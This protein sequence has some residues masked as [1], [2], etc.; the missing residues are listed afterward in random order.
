MSDINSYIR[1]VLFN[2]NDGSTITAFGFVRKA[3]LVEKIASEAA[4]A[5]NH[6]DPEF[7]FDMSSF[8]DSLFRELLDAEVIVQEGDFFAGEFYKLDQQS[9]L[10]FRNGSLGS[11]STFAQAQRVGSSFYPAVFSNFRTLR[12][13]ADIAP[14]FGIPLPASDRV[15]TLGHN[16]IGD[17]D[18]ASTDLIDLVAAETDVDGDPSLRDQFLG[19]LKA[20]RELIREKTLSAYLLHQ[21]VMSLLGRLIEKYKGKAIGES[22]R[23]LFALLV[24]HIFSDS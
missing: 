14:N 10:S 7:S 16:A 9:F 23:A 18:G 8:A 15:V 24:Q 3:D 19:Q 4:A 21:T 5:T 20:G 1:D 17:L 12:T 11:S 2:H 6:Y 13:D 22:A